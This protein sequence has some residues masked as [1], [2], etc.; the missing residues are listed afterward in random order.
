[1]CPAA[2][3]KARRP[4]I[5]IYVAPLRAAFRTYLAAM[6]LAIFLYTAVVIAN[7]GW[8]LLAVFFG[9]M[10]RMGWPDQFNLDFMFLLTLSALWLGWRHGFSARAWRWRSSRQW[11]TRRFLACICWS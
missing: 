6:A 2:Q 8:K 4:R 1:M 3:G 5:V 10:G 9:D 11:A 7:H